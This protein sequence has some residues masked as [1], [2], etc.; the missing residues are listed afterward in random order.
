M[1]EAAARLEEAGMGDG[2][3]TAVAEV[4]GVTG[5]GKLDARSWNTATA[6]VA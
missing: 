4:A 5:A 6:G 1:P 3:D 2:G